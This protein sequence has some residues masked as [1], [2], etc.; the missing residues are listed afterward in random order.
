MPMETTSIRFSKGTLPR[1]KTFAHLKSL[2]SGRTVT[3][4]S[5]VRELVEAHFLGS[6]QHPAATNQA[7]NAP[8]A[9]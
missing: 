6:E 5:L 2:E 4:N 7:V 3:W 8:E 9:V 1:L